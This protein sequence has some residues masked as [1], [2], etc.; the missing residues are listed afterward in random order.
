MHVSDA[1]ME[2]LATYLRFY[3]HYFTLPLLRITVRFLFTSLNADLI[4]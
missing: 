1:R 3:F 4:I 2:S